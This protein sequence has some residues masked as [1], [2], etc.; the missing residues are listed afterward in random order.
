MMCGWASF[1]MIGSWPTLINEVS[2]PCRSYRRMHILIRCRRFH[3][4]ELR[5]YKTSQTVYQG[6]HVNRK[7]PSIK[8]NAYSVR[9]MPSDEIKRAAVIWIRDDIRLSDHAPWLAAS[10]VPQPNLVLPVY[11]LSPA[12]LHPRCDI[13]Q[14]STL[15]TLGPYRCRWDLLVLP[16]RFNV[17]AFPV[18]FA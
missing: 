8:P 1:P 15:P 6:V 5:S 2:L 11:C 9:H 12:L 7:A 4:R 3:S 13:P 18:D 16:Y 10:S 14:L 17:H